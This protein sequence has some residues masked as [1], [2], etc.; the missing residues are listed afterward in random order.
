M[1]ISITIELFSAS[2]FNRCSAAKQRVQAIVDGLGEYDAI[3]YREIDVLDELD[4]TVSLGI[5]ITPA[6]AIDG[7]L[8]FTAMPS[9]EQLRNHVQQRLDEI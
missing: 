9:M 7:K 8:V 4:Y 3:H 6:I 1:V 5:L 2:S